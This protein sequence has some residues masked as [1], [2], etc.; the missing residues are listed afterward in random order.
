MSEKNS[1]VIDDIIKDLKRIPKK[2]TTNVDIKLLA[3][4]VSKILQ[5]QMTGRF[6]S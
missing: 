4:E 6:S 2:V 1:K 3:N 5:R